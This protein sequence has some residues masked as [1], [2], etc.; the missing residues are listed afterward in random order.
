[1]GSDILGTHSPFVFHNIGMFPSQSLDSRESIVIFRTKENVFMTLVLCE[2][3]ATPVLLN[4]YLRNFRV[5]EY[6][7]ADDPSTI[8]CTLSTLCNSFPAVWKYFN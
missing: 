5:K 7:L 8:N 3:N 1:M 4:K 6:K 2:D